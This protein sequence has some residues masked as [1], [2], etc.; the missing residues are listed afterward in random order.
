MIVRVTPVFHSLRF[1][2]LVFT[3]ASPP[4]D[5]A[6]PFSGCL[7][8]L[9]LFSK[10]WPILYTFFVLGRFPFCDPRLVGFLSRAVVYVVGRLLS[11]NPVWGLI[12][13]F[14]L[15]FPISKFGEIF[16]R[17]WLSSP[18]LPTLFYNRSFPRWYL[19]S[20]VGV[21]SPLRCNTHVT[22]LNTLRMLS[23]MIVCN[24]IQNAP[25]Q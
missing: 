25:A 7:H 24:S 12:P 19:P 23:R 22:S 18:L 3:I 15:D 10:L 16:C 13:L 11:P 4:H 21:A 5:G 9:S 14:L 17:S 6:F 2:A 1:F 20:S 8:L